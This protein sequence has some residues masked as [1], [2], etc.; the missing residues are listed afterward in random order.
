MTAANLA[1]LMLCGWDA[2]SVRQARHFLSLFS[3]S[4]QESIFAAI[5]KAHLT[6]DEVIPL[7]E[8]V[9]KGG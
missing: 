7:L 5:A 6:P 1:A 4:D 3:A 9:Q 8:E 2:D